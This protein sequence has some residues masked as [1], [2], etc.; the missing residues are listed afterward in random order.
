MPLIA[1]EET[2]RGID[3]VVDKQIA[4]WESEAKSGQSYPIK[5]VVT[6]SRQRGTGGSF[7]A[8]RMAEELD[9]NMFDRLALSAIADNPDFLR[10]I[11]DSLREPQ[12]KLLDEWISGL[13]SDRPEVENDYFTRLYHSV[14]AVARHGGIVLVGRAC[15]FIL[16][17]QNGFHL[18]V[19]A[20]ESFRV[21]NL[22]EFSNVDADIAMSAVRESD[23]ERRAFVRENFSYD[24]D[25]PNYYDLM[26][27]RAFLG[28]EESVD[29]ALGAARHKFRALED[30]D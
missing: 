19:H 16:T 20:P 27:N 11:V 23:T 12:R 15:N 5:P 28:L 3:A 4:A 1:R 25:D 26:V 7:I 8:R 14:A 30:A 18:R 29:L 21:Q 22:V 10:R 9:Y 17:L 2:V 13:Q 6:I 24:I